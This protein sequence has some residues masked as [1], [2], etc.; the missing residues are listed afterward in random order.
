M[1]IENLKNKHFYIISNTLVWPFNNHDMAGSVRNVL[2]LIRYLDKNFIK[3]YFISSKVGYQWVEKNGLSSEH[4]ITSTVN[5]KITW[6]LAWI[7]ITI[8]SLFFRPKIGNNAILYSEAEFL[9][10]TIPILRWKKNGD[11]W[12]C[13][14]RSLAP[15][16]F[17]F[18]DLRIIKDPLYIF[19]QW[20]SAKI[21]IKYADLVFV[22]N[23]EIKKQMLKYGVQESKIKV[24][25]NGID[26]NMVN[27]VTDQDKKYEAVFVGR[28]M[29]HKGIFDLMEIWQ[30]VMIVFPDAKIIILGN[31]EDYYMKNVKAE[32]NNLGLENNFILKGF[33]DGVEKYK[34]IKQSKILVLPSYLEGKP[35]AFNDGMSSKLPIVAYELS[36]YREF[37]G[38]MINYTVVGDKDGFANAIIKLLQNPEEAKLQ[39]SKGYNFIS[40]YDWRNVIDKNINYINKLYEDA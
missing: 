15:R 8:V 10:N 13:C 35:N 16:K 31:G 1:S 32:I 37:Y 2:E 9:P 33:I 29:H 34:L 17:C 6:F 14:V 4:I 26:L 40:Q 21:F 12:I 20:L 22:V 39:G 11:K 5:N 18:R 24:I 38:S 7:W 3:H 36:Y 23:H 28:I 19:S 27:S 30:K 25:D